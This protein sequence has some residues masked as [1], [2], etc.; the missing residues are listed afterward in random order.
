LGRHRTAHEERGLK[1]RPATETRRVPVPPEL[2]TILRHDIATFSTARDGRIFSS[3][4]GQVVASTAISDVWAE[5]RTLALPPGQVASP[6]ADRP[7]DLR[8]AAVS[9]RLNAGVS[10]Q[11][12]AHR[13]GHGVEVLLRVYA[14]C[15][16]GGETVANNRIAAALKDA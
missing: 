8:H 2:V 5:A 11:D 12:V 16:D 1:H 14:K 3:D 7:C 9:L 6:L 4:R 10:P 13:A 15:L